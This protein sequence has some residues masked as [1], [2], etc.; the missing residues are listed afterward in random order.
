[1][2]PVPVVMAGVLA[3]D[4]PQVPFAVDGHP[5][6]ALGSRCVS[7]SRRSNSRAVPQA[8]FSRASRSTR[9]RMSWLVRRRP[10]RPRYVH[11]RLIRRRCQASH[12]ARCDEPMGA[13]HGWQQPGQ[14]RQDRPVGPVRLGPG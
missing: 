7:I 6:G 5:V 14:S 2:G 10:G 13:Q 11:L 1:V 3:E 4:R 8:G 12:R 9:L